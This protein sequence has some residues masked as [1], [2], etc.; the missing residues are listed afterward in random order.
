MSL[1]PKGLEQVKSEQCTEQNMFISLNKPCYQAINEMR[2]QVQI[3]ILAHKL[4][5]PQA[6]TPTRTRMQ[7]HTN[8]HIH[9]STT[10]SS[11]KRREQF[12]TF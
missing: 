12:D 9:A 1:Q 10:I 6:H 5:H 7:A 8:A 2:P 3:Q 11:H 4:A